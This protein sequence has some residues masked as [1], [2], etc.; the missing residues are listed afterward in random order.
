MPELPEVETVCRTLRAL[1]R[2][3]RIIKIEVLQSR[4]R[5]RIAHN[6][7]S[8]LLGGTFVDVRRRGKYI[9]LILDREVIWV[10]HLGMSG[11]LIYV[12]GERPREK[13]DH[14]C[15]GLENGCELRYHDPRRFGLSAAIPLGELARWPPIRDLGPDPLGA[16]F[17]PAR[18]YEAASKSRRRI[19]DLLLDQ[20]VVAGLGNIYTNEILYR[21]GVRPTAR[22][23]HLGRYRIHEIA[24]ATPGLL[25]QAIQWGGTSFSD[26]RDGEDRRGEFQSHLHVYGRE[27]EPCR[28][29]RHIIKR[30]SL[31]NRSAFY[32][33]SCQR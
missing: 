8:L 9:L 13:H 12:T 27:G 7:E 21:A 1:V 14:I 33:P 23:F 22:A 5:Q 2:G 16:D 29:C 11:K 28:R 19:R 20:R 32:C 3:R 10:V 26:Y 17:T 30:A 24:A 25:N 4:L 31:G 6:F 15:A 18:L